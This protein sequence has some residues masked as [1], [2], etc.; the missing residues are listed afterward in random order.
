MIRNRRFFSRRHITILYAQFAAGKRKEQVMDL[1]AICVRLNRFVIESEDLFWRNWVGLEDD[2]DVPGL[3]TKYKSIFTLDSIDAVRNALKSAGDPDRKRFYRAVLGQI[4]LSYLEYVSAELQQEILK[5]EA[6]TTVNWRNEEVPIR[7]FRVRILNTQDRDIRREMM[8][9]RGNVEDRLINPL[10]KQLVARM[11]QSVENMG[12]GNYVELCEETQNRDFG[13][14]ALEMETFLR[15]TESVYCEYLDQYLRKF[16]GVGLSDNAHSSD[17]AAIMRCSLFDGDF[18]PEKLMPVLKN[19][20][21]GMG[22]TLDKI[23]LDLESRPR[24]KTRPC[25]SAVNP[26]DDVRLTLSPVGGFEDYSGLLH[27]VGHALHFTHERS[28]LEFIYKFWGDRGFTE[29]TAYLFQN[30]TMNRGWLKELAGVDD[31]EDLIRYCAFMALLRFRRLAGSFL[32]QMELFTSRD[33]SSVRERYR[34]H[35]ERAHQVSF[36]TDDYL[37]FDMELYSAGYLRARMFEIQLRENMVARY[38]ENW[39][40]ISEAGEYLRAIFKDGRKNRA[41]DVVRQLGYAGL[42]SS[43]YRDRYVRYLQTGA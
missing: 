8:D 15:E 30:I 35:V 19:T 4:T 1:N 10:R 6:Q 43:F 18:P 29:G 34:F 38:G 12:Y 13:E 40:K 26:P 39:W 17:I 7:A 11:K 31:P 3:Y 20:I 9:L 27:E 5:K 33:L 23:H 25:V 42:S 36:N 2:I 21:A 28:D 41:D 22:F 24:K 14:F 16:A 37:T 32:Y